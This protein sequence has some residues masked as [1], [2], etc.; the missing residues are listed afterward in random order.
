[1]EILFF[2]FLWI[3][4]A[5]G[6]AVV[7]KRNGRSY[8]KYLLI[9]IF[10]SPLA[11]FLILLILGKNEEGIVKSKIQTKEYKICPFCAELIKYDAIV[12]RYCGGEIVRNPVIEEEDENDD[13]HFCIECQETMS[14]KEQY[15]PV[16][17][18][19]QF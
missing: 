4:L 16:C 2:I 5:I 8:I 9:S 7:A 11:G 19:K 10:L 12:C 18:A 3:L 17:G 13:I 1:M 6:A 14:Y 15:C